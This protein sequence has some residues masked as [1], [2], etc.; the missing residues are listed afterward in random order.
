MSESF[1]P[2]FA[3]AGGRTFVNSEARALPARKKTAGAFLCAAAKMA[4]KP[5]LLLPH[6]KLLLLAVQYARRL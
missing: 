3:A 2:Q 4:A 5:I 6:A 1:L